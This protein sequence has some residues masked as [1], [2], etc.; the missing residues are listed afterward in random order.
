MVDGYILG[1]SIECLSA[2]IISRKFDIKGLL[3]L[4]TGKVVIS[5]NCT[6]DSYAEIVKALPKGFDE[7]DRF[8]KT[9]KTALGDS[10][11]GKSINFYFL[12]FKPITP[13]KAPKVSHTHNSQELTTNS[14][15]CADISLPFQ[16]IANAMM[17]KD[18][19]KKITE[20]KKQ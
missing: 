13:K 14:Q 18:N 5:Y 2:H 4:P 19:S 12:G 9:A 3:K 11:N 6:R 8:D 16:H 10:I 1:S 15:T 7:K 17:K 20:G